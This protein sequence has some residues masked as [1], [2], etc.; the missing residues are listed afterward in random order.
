[1]EYLAKSIGNEFA[2]INIAE[3][4]KEYELYY[5]ETIKDVS[6]NNVVV[7]RLEGKVTIAQLNRQKEDLLKMVADVDNKINAIT[8]LSQK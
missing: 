1:M 6:D 8:S 4:Q 5:L 3:D 7:P 2:E